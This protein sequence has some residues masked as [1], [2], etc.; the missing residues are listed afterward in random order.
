MPAK[1]RKT[2]GVKVFVQM[3]LEHELSEY[4][5]A[6]F[7]RPSPLTQIL[8]NLDYFS[9]CANCER[10]EEKRVNRKLAFTS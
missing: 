10:Y 8:T 4:S 6:Y 5:G 3:G 7:C 1:M 2:S 9:F